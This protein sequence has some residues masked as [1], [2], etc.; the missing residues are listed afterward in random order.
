MFSDILNGSQEKLY[1]HL[2]GF[3]KYMDIIIFNILRK[4]L[5]FSRDLGTGLEIGM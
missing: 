3:C 4:T 5:I 2:C 1:V